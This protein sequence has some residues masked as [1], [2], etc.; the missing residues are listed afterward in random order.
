MGCT[1][2]QPLV[3]LG[4]VAVSG[5]ERRLLYRR[6]MVGGLPEILDCRR[7]V[8]DLLRQLDQQSVTC[9]FGR[10][11]RPGGG[12]SWFFALHQSGRSPTGING[13]ILGL[14]HHGS[15]WEDVGGEMCMS[16]TLSTPTWRANLLTPNHS[17]DGFS[18]GI[19]KTATGQ[20]PGPGFFPD[21]R[22]SDAQ[23][24]GAWERVGQ[25]IKNGAMARERVPSPPEGGLVT[26]L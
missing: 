15:P 22:H 1:L 24:S 6:L 16:L 2:F 11:R 10:G 14:S 26:L 3:K 21:R 5:G 19:C 23:V 4:S 17:S 12:V 25:Q 18:H 13:V 8:L 9:S 20:K 7:Q